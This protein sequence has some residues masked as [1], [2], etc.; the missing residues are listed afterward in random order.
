[1]VLVFELEKQ[2][3]VTHLSTLEFSGDSV[4]GNRNSLRLSRRKK[5]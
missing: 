2:A 5:L 1:M 4:G 3:S